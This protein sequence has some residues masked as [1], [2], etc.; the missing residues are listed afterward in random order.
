MDSVELWKYTADK[1]ISL[2][3]IQYDTP[4]PVNVIPKS[5]PE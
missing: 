4:T 1:V 5:L 3:Y 2:S